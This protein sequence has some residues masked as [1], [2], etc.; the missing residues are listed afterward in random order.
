M[1]LRKLYKIITGNNQRSSLIRKNIIGS[2]LIKGWSGLVQLLLVPA[3]LF[4]LGNYENGIWMTISSILVWI[5]SLDIGLGNG[6][7]NR[8][9]TQVAHDDWEGARTS[10]SSTFG[11]LVILIIPI[12]ILLMA[13]VNVIDLYSVLNVDKTIVNNLTKVFMMSIALICST[14]IFKFIGNVYM[15]MQL[16]AVNNALVTIGQT[17][18]L[19]LVFAMKMANIHSLMLV[20]VAYTLSPLIVYLIA[21]PITFG[22]LFP[23]LRPSLSYFSWKAVKGLLTTGVKFFVLQIAGVIL[24]ASSNILISNFFNPSLVTPYQIAYR[25]FSLMIIFFTIIVTPFWS[26]TTDAYA[27]GDIEWIRNSMTKIHKIM[28]LVGILLLVMVGISHPVYLLWVGSSVNIP[29]SMSCLMAAYIYII[30]YSMSYS[31]FL[32]GIGVLHM[33]LLFTI[34][35]AIIYI[36]IAYLLSR[37]AG[38]NGMIMALA[39]V[40]L[41]GLIVNCIQFNKIIKGTAKGIWKR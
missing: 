1:N 16:P 33:Q 21:Y 29:L 34:T 10:V 8:L 38:I 20:A 35:A 31:F 18:V 12:A 28:L 36:P 30:L 4:C 22:K 37:I 39:L 2:F 6:M 25:Y 3:T 9:A 5:D 26:A 7:R 27:R 11:M 40:N 23:R 13:L 17:L 41:P 32:N 15:G 24:F 14:F 19:A